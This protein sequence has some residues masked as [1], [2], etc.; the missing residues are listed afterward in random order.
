M[1]RDHWTDADWA[2]LERQLEKS[3]RKCD[4][5]MRELG[6]TPPNR[7][8]YYILNDQGQPV[9]STMAKSSVWLER[10]NEKRI[11]KQEWIENVQVS[12]IF[13]WI[14]HAWM[15]GPPVLWETM[16]FSNRKNFDQDSDRCGGN[17]EQAE[18]MHERM[19]AKVRRS[20]KN[21]PTKKK[22]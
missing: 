4:E 17:R 14:D 16:T 19:C 8:K 15:G 7:T 12:T 21:K 11:V 1:N 6:I 13:L 18:A 10:Y 22:K 9:P 20:L 3:A 2:D 5:T